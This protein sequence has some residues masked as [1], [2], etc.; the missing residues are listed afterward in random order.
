MNAWCVNGRHSW[1]ISETA[2]A[3]VYPFWGDLFSLV[4]FWNTKRRNTRNTV[5]FSPCSFRWAFYL[6]YQIV[7][8]NDFATKKIK[9]KKNILSRQNSYKKKSKRNIKLQNF[10]YRFRVNFVLTILKFSVQV[11]LYCG[12]STVCFDLWTGKNNEN[13]HPLT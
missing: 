13:V 7:Y 3:T 11:F 10:W 6:Q 4:L 8:S 5:V 12:T 2:A 9:R 1:L